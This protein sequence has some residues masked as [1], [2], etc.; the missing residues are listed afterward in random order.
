MNP[1]Y[2]ARTELLLGADVLARL[3]EVRV[4]L[5]GCG[6]VGSWCAEGLVRSG[7]K[8]LTLVDAD[9]VSGSNVNRQLM[10]TPRTVGREIGRAHV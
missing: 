4:L 3:A 9:V 6:G 8:Q 7:V 2:T 1:D 10:A 5:F